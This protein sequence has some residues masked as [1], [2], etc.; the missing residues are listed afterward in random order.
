MNYQLTM[1]TMPSAL[2]SYFNMMSDFLLI[3][4]IRQEVVHV[5]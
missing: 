3:R 2:S 5:I 4:L 1:A